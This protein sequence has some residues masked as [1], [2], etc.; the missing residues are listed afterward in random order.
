[1]RRAT[2]QVT[3]LASRHPFCNTIPAHLQ[4][5]LLSGGPKAGIHKVSKTDVHLP[6]PTFIK[7]YTNFK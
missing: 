7:I 3:L 2:N 6:M 4:Q 1:M 5:G